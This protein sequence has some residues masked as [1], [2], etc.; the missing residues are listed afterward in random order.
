VKVKTKSQKAEKLEPSVSTK[1][2][3]IFISRKGETILQTMTRKFKF[4]TKHYP[5]GEFVTS[6]DGQPAG[7]GRF[8]ELKISGKQ[9]RLGAGRAKPGAGHRVE[10]DV[11]KIDR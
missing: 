5:I 11:E 10:W 9:S 8:W 6:I 1:K 7:R 2:R 4:R 3:K